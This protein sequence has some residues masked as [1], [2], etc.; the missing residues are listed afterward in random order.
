M[1]WITK[2]RDGSGGT[3]HGKEGAGYYKIQN[4]EHGGALQN[5][6]GLLDLEFA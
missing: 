3:K 4:A 6:S 5:A 2:S 1:L